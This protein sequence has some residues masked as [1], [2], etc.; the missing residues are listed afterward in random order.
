MK[1]LLE[2]WR[3]YLAESERADSM[4]DEYHAYL[5]NSGIRER[6]KKSHPAA[7]RSHQMFKILRKSLP[8]D[9]FRELF[10]F[11][12]DVVNG[13]KKISDL[14]TS[15]GPQKKEYVELQSAA[16]KEYRAIREIMRKAYK[17]IYNRHVDRDF[18][19]SLTLVHW[20]PNPELYLTTDSKHQTSAEGYLP[21]KPIIQKWGTPGSK[22][23]GAYGYK[24]TAP[25]KIQGT[26]VQIKGHV[27]MATNTM[28]SGTGGGYKA[29][30]GQEASGF[31]KDID[32]PEAYSTDPGTIFRGFEHMVDFFEKKKDTKD[33]V[34]GPESFK[35]SKKFWDKSINEFVVDNW[36]P[37]ALVLV[38]GVKNEH[39]ARMSQ[40]ALE[41]KLPLIDENRNPIE[42]EDSNETPT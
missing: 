27:V 6:I 28:G 7:Q 14:P 29:A 19:K 20:D 2:N 37:V 33:T 10:D 11:S 25:Q 8:E 32:A 1:L 39:Y 26:G 34:M 41:N 18:L 22:G 15:W 24:G 21:N 23:S 13:V 12:I 3:K 4:M 5:E 38:G 40:I 16:Q 17:K 35:G 42:T 30:P 31:S 9:E 36:A